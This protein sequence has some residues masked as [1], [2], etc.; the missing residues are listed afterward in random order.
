MIDP[1]ILYQHGGNVFDIAKT[2]G[3]S[4]SD[5]IDLS[6][7][8][9][10][11]PP[12]FV[13]GY[14][15]DHSD[16]IQMLPEPDSATLLNRLAET[17]HV[18]ASCLALGA[19]T[20]ELIQW[21]CYLHASKTVLLLQPTYSDY[22]KYAHL[23]DL[24]ILRMPLHADANFE[25]EIDSF[26]QMAQQSQLVFFC[27]PNNP[28][29]TVISHE[30]LTS[31]L[32][33]CPETLFIIDESYMPFVLAEKD[34]SMVSSN[35]SNL[36]VLR[37]I[38]KI[39]GLP[40]LRVGWAISPNEVL[41]TKIRKMISLWSLNTLG[42]MIAAELTSYDTLEIAKEH[43]RIKEQFL[44]DLAPLNWLH[45]YPSQT[46]YV[47]FQSHRYTAQEI[48]DHCYSQQILI[49]D[50]SNFRGLDGQFIRIAM[51][52]ESVME[53]AAIHLNRLES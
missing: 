53:K 1:N 21:L 14:L 28:T 29:G 13:E 6:G 35:L 48:Y 25:L 38:S 15:K 31:I 17:H 47:L 37:S 50:C 8:V 46:N 19:G 51:K 7:N 11:S 40:G 12:P 32:N 30:V 36:L 22:E 5:I 2:L 44:K 4:P 34:C 43:H 23:F 26:C 45:P 18:S 49:R 10:P 20:T 42:Q 9:A 39:F 16:A 33:Q 41:I 24:N 27:N 3:I 52:E